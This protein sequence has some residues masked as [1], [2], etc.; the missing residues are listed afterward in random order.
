MEEKYKKF[1]N[2]DWKNS[3]EYKEYFSKNVYISP[4][5]TGDKILKARKKF[6]KLKV[7]PDFDINYV[8]EEPNKKKNIK[9]KSITEHFFYA[10][11][12]VL[13]CI[14]FMN[15]LMPKYILN[16]AIVVISLRFLRINFW[17]FFQTNPIKL[18]LEEEH[19]HLLLYSLYL[20]L[21]KINY[22]NLFP[23]T[24]TSVYSI[25]EYLVD[26]LRIFKFIKTYFQKI[27]DHKDKV[28]Q[29]RGFSYIIIG[30]LLI[31]RIIVQWTPFYNGFIYSVFLIY[32]FYYD[33]YVRISFQKINNKLFK[34]K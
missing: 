21:D 25:G 13:W 10:I 26:Y 32:L 20:K 5:I 31:P 22:F 19:F 4:P 16:V 3:E 7:D 34:K 30:L 12:C 18:I 1:L 29:A 17:N 2:F 8:Y 9:K 11:E 28:F 33:K 15:L 6:Y 14:Y 24:C 27:I 23:F